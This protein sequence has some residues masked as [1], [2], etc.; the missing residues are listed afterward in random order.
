MKKSNKRTS[1]FEKEHLRLMKYASVESK[2][3]ALTA[4]V[5]FA[6]EAQK[7]YKKRG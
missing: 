4:M 5:E 3:H 7:N 2:F 1:G 6:K